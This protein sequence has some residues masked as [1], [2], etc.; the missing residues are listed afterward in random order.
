VGSFQRQIGRG[1]K[2]GA[3]SDGNAGLPNGYLQSLDAEK[4]HGA[5]LENQPTLMS[6][7]PEEKKIGGTTRFACVEPHIFLFGSAQEMRTKRWLRR[8]GKSA[9]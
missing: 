5:C 1:C 4:L 7:H 8:V 3:E 2:P 9:A 6:I